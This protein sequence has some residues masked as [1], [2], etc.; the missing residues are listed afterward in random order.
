MNSMD[1]HIQQTNDR[2]QCIKQVSQRW[3]SLSL[4]CVLYGERVVHHDYLL[5]NARPCLLERRRVVGMRHFNFIEDYLLQSW[6]IKPQ[7]P[8]FTIH[9]SKKSSAW[10]LTKSASA[11]SRV[12]LVLPALP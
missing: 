10:R 1:R 6:C 5:L 2:L 9:L 7:K 8:N 12:V 4:D 11:E 3:R